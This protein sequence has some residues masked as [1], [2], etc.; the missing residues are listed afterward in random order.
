MILFYR[1][2][3]N[4]LKVKQTQQGQTIHWIIMKI[5]NQSIDSHYLYNYWIYY[6][7]FNKILV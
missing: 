7:F 5:N 2:Q 3:L 1:T 6:Y 4:L